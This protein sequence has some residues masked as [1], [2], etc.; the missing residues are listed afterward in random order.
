MRGQSDCRSRTIMN[1][2]AKAAPNCWPPDPTTSC[3]KERRRRRRVS[4]DDP[5]GGARAYWLERSSRRR[6]WRG[7]SERGGAWELLMNKVKSEDF[8]AISRLART[9]FSASA[10]LP[11]AP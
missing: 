7:S 4:K 11:I 5:G 3:L 10:L 2:I 8:D 9:S 6:A 1:A